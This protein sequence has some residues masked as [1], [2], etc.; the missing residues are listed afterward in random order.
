LDR[1]LCWLLLRELGVDNSRLL[2][3]QQVGK[4]LQLR[5]ERSGG[6]DGGFGG[7][8]QLLL[9]LIDKGSCLNHWG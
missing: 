6:D 5:N 2:L 1:L 9:H 7:C 8:Q 3:V 4:R